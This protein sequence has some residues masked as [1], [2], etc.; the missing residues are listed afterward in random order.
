MTSALSC[1][2]DHPIT[3]AGGRSSKGAT[4]YKQHLAHSAGSQTRHP[5]T[6]LRDTPGPMGQPS[7]ACHESQPKRNLRG[8]NCCQQRGQVAS[9]ALLWYTASQ[10]PSKEADK[11]S[12]DRQADPKLEQ[13]HTIL[14]ELFHQLALACS[15]QSLVTCRHSTRSCMVEDH[16]D[17]MQG[18]QLEVC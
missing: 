9:P 16:V 15:T 17:D 12:G 7:T 13:A 6:Q 4:S 8:R 2:I 18:M 5:Q 10:A 3:T 1:Y 14:G 11:L